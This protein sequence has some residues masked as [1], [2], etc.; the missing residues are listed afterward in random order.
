MMGVMGTHKSL[1]DTIRERLGKARACRAHP[2][3]ASLCPLSSWENEEDKL[4]LADMAP[5]SGSGVPRANLTQLCLPL[6]NC[7]KSVLTEID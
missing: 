1:A 7:E 2:D 4:R 5:H 6:I 3:E